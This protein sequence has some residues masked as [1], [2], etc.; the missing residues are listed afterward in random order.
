[1]TLSRSKKK[2]KLPKIK[3]K[4]SLHFFLFGLFFILILLGLSHLKKPTRFPIVDVKVFG[5]THL[6][7]DQVQHFLK[8]LV[9]RG[10]FGIEIDEVKNRLL[11]EPWI[12]EVNV[13]RIWPN[14]VYINIIE[15]TPIAIW[16]ETSLLSSKGELF[17]PGENNLPADL[18]QLIG[19]E[20][21]QLFMMENYFKIASVV[22]PL[23]FKITR[24][25]W[26]SGQFWNLTLDNGIKITANNKDILTRLGHFVKVYQKIIGERANDVDYVDLRYSN[27]LA[28]KWKTTT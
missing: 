7:R 22:K 10:F 4:S 14:Q 11:Q 8:P 21:K 28:V 17:N 19:P 12:A 23:S 13:R 15:K 18:P 5:A 2:S 16:N 3:W 26:M 25:E 20:S 6:N 1:M 9:Q 24:L 27:G